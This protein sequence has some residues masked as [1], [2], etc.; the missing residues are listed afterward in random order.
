MD[1]G[2]YILYKEMLRIKNGSYDTFCLG[3]FGISITHYT[4]ENT[5]YPH[6]TEKLYRF[7]CRRFLEACDYVK[8][9]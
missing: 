5:I 1:T 9:N 8:K 6:G 7:C 3:E 4:E 2:I